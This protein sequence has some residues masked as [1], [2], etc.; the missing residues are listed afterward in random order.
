MIGNSTVPAAR[1]SRSFDVSSLNP[2][3]PM[4]EKRKALRPKAA[5]GKD[6]AVPLESG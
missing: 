6:V 4:V 5:R 3:A 2:N 1:R